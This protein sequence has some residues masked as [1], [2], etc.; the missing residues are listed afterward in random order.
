MP[1]SSPFPQQDY[2]LLDFETTG[3]SS[4]QDEIIEVGAIRMSGFEIID[5]FES[6]VK[7]SKEI[8]NAIVQLTG[9]SNEMVADAPSI[10]TIAPRLAEFLGDLPLVAHNSQMEQDFLDQH[11]SPLLGGLAFTVHNSIEPLALLLPERSSHSLENLR[12]WAGETSAQSHRALQ[13]C[14][15][16]LVV[17]KYAY[18]YCAKERPWIASLSNH[19]LPAWWWNW[20]FEPIAND[21]EE[22]FSL[23]N[24]FQRESLGDLRAFQK[25]DQDR[26]TPDFLELPKEQL[27]EVFEQAPSIVPGLQIRPSQKRMSDEIRSTFERGGKVAIEAPT[28]TGKSL[29]YLVPS[30]LLSEQSQLPV[31]ISTH[32]KALQDQLFDKDFATAAAITDQP[33]ASATTVKGQENYLC[34]RKLYQVAIDLPDEATQA[35]I[36]ERYSVAFVIAFQ[37]LSRLAELDRVSAYIRSRIEPMAHLL[38]RVKSHHQTTI[39]PQCP[40]YSSCHF[41]N[42]ARL[43]HQSQ[44]IVANHSL[45]FHWPDHLPKLRSVVFDEAHHLE[46]QLTQTYS[47]E[48]SERELGDAFERLRSQGR[49]RSYSDA[50]KIASAF[51]SNE[52]FAAFQ[53][54]LEQLIESFKEWG[55]LVPSLIQ[56]RGTRE[57]LGYEDTLRLETISEHPSGAVL[58]KFRDK[59][60]TI[61]EKLEELRKRLEDSS[62]RG[63]KNRSAIIDTIV[64]YTSRFSE[65]VT[66]LDRALGNDANDLRLLLWHSREG[67]W[68]IRVFPIE[69]AAHGAEFFS[70]IR[71]AIFTSATL[72][73]GAN[74][75][76]F[77]KRV[78]AETSKP[79]V[80]LPSPFDLANQAR[81]YIARG[82][83]NPGSAQHL[84]QV[85]S[86]TEQSA[87]ILG[88]R[89]LVLFSA[90][91]RLK[92]AAEKLRERLEPH[93]IEV[94]DSITDKRALDHFKQSARGVLV[95]GERYGEGVDIP[96]DQLSMVVI[97][98]MNEMMT[99]GA[100]ADARKQRVRFGLF[101][102]D[103][104][105][106]MIWLKQRV[107][108]LIRSATDR[109]SVV[110]FDP[111]YYAWSAPSQNIVRQTLA[112]MQIR[113]LAVD[114]ILDE[115]QSEMNPS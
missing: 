92:A 57:S 26:E 115:L 104:P 54:Q 99:R 42:S 64:P 100:L 71:S 86:F 34:L 50:A 19:L 16:L 105:L 60:K 47:E 12:I 41:F 38:E 2:I 28:G 77:L 36:H 91:S 61:T 87:R 82:V 102:Y 101:D 39:G 37:K 4:T 72:S 33:Q 29:A 97:E 89:T 93:G 76:F 85:I 73:A 17:L 43:A 11:V 103:F 45:V 14:D 112:P 90:N 32:S 111:R 65:I 7:P 31:V 46:D 15:D 48:L 78:G 84:E 23:L 9:I 13:D 20:F 30:L 95:G 25:E 69:V 75:D 24:L 113:E 88:G 27:A 6:F 49:P 40:F 18:D 59:L 94:F 80:K 1:S 114:P 10:A 55:R 83:A 70:E 98:K 63:G 58:G 67:L 22:P 52:E 8:P 96:G 56:A 5:R 107:G 44:I 66:T 109:G 62:S 21:Q 106:R 68:R 81:V 51:D 74:D 79:L 108:R 110:I 35:G 53:E 3:L